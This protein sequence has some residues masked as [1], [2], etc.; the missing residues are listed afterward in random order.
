MKNES[1]KVQFLNIT[2]LTEFRK[3]SHPSLHRESGTAADAPQ[4]C[5]H[6]CLPGVPDTWNELLYAY[7]LNMGF[8]KKWCYLGKGNYLILRYND[9]ILRA[10]TIWA[11]SP[12]VSSSGSNP[13]FS[14]GSTSLLSIS[15]TF[16]SCLKRSNLSGPYVEGICQRK[17]LWVSDV[18]R[19]EVWR[20]VPTMRFFGQNPHT[21][22]GTYLWIAANMAACPTAV[23]CG[24]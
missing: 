8:K 4:D 20:R 23:T 19:F 9:Y 16:S 1:R 17:I 12:Q 24:T 22:P 13:A 6:W 3:D 10:V 7:L 2:Y 15:F 14:S 21:K 5:S 11:G 18:Y